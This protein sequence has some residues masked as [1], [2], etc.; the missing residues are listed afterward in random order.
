M[1]SWNL[2]EKNEFIEKNSNRATL[3]ISSVLLFYNVLLARYVPLLCITAVRAALATRKRLRKNDL[4]YNI[5]ECSVQA[6]V[7]VNIF[8][9]Q[10]FRL[11]EMK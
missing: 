3:I 7:K 5:C 2:S 11:T 4:L 10:T 1:R 8:I 9:I 6:A